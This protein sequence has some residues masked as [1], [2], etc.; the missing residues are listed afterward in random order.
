MELLSKHYG[1]RDNNF[2]LL[3]LVGASLV[4][5]GHSY[6]LF[7]G[8]FVNAYIPGHI[9]VQIFF[10]ISGFLV[11]QSFFRRPYFIEY[12]VARI[13]RIFPGLI[14]ALIFSVLLGAMVSKLSLGEYFRNP[15]VWDYFYQNSILNIRWELPGVF[16]NNSFPKVVNGS[17]W[18]LP[19]EFKLYIILMFFG[20]AGVLN[21]SRAIGNVCAALLI[22]AHTNK[23]VTYGLTGGDRNVDDVVFCFLLG[24]LFFTNRDS[25]FISLRLAIACLFAAALSIKYEFYSFL[26]V[27]FCIAYLVIVFAYNKKIQINAFKKFDY[28]YGLYIYAFPIQQ[29][30]AEFG[31][32]KNFEVYVIASFALTLPFAM[33]SWVYIEKPALRLRDVIQKFMI[34]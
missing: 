10:V 15:L 28:S 5:F 4:I 26:I 8:D 23:M 3:R 11:A 2:N 24:V 6:A 22:I 13:L 21:S 1:N 32:I 7:K 27:Q 25:I 16:L 18:T 12:L 34:P 29:A 17:L 30:L 33:V 19:I 20:I 9:G 14:V 31:V